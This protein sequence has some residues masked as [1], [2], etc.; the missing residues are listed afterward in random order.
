MTIK[1]IPFYSIE[2]SCL[3]NNAV[4][5]NG[6]K[7]ALKNIFHKLVSLFKYTRLARIVFAVYAFNDVITVS[8]VNPSFQGVNISTFKIAISPN[9]RKIPFCKFDDLVAVL[10]IQLHGFNHK[11]FLSVME[12]HLNHPTFRK[13]SIA[14][15]KD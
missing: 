4:F 8:C 15:S 14:S 5:R 10:E 1:I 12:C 3:F 9:Q 2:N 11:R 7:Q 13:C 6:Q